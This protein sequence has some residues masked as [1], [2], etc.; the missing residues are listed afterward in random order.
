VAQA[1]SVRVTSS[2][3]S[4]LS[5]VAV[6]FAVTAGG[7]TIAGA[8]QV[9]NSSGIAT[10][11]SWTLGATPGINTA[12]ATVAGLTPVTFSATATPVDTRATQDR[13]DEVTGNQVH[14]MYV[15][16]SDGA[17]RELDRN[18]TLASSVGS[19]QTWLAGQ[20]GGRRLRVDTF[21][22]ALDVT[23]VR[24]TRT[25]A[26][27][28]SYGVFA[29]DTLEKDLQAAGFAGATKIYAVYFDGPNPSTCGGGA[30]P[31]VL[32][33]RVA[34]LYLRGT[35]PGAPPCVANPFATS[36]TAA[37]GYLE[38]AML[39]EIMHTMGFVASNAPNHVLAGH[40]GDDN[41]DLMYAGSLPWQPSILDVGR[42]DYFGPT[43]PAG[44]LNLA[45]SPFLLP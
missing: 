9:T 40:A 18:G 39:H 2:S 10:A 14:V 43:V 24:L 33:G 32:P 37:P 44:V 29:R 3:G 11:T 36:A 15:L 31:P 7:G 1:P 35:P 4:T 12:T 21:N 8:S 27:M 25:N 42:N 41:R 34:A 30:W 20:T 6:T 13:L 22:G 16:S 19:F 5:G 17:D 38:Y 28:T 23:F 26:Q 45:N